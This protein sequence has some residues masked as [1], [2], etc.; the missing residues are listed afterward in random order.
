MKNK[1][2]NKD[3]TNLNEKVAIYTR[4]S[5]DEQ[6]NLNQIIKLKKYAEERRY[7]YD[8]YTDIQSSKKTR[9]TKNILLNRIRSGVKYDAVIVWSLDRWAR[10]TIELLGDINELL[11]RGVNFI[12]YNED[13]SVKES[14]IEA[15]RMLASFYAFELKMISERTKLG[16]ERA[17]QQG[18]KLGRP[19]G[20]KDTNKRSNVNYLIREA[21]KRRDAD[22]AE[23]KHKSLL[24]Y[25]DKHKTNDFDEM[26]NFIKSYVG[27][28]ISQGQNKAK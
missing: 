20:S 25:L 4:V 22:E 13:I 1:H 7:D 15:I 27:K 10:N 19:F 6:N 26:E 17:R 2:K 21:V 11:N 3:N 16:L 28:R 23:G 5:T 9:P 24:Y 14:G 12:S 8:I 18:K